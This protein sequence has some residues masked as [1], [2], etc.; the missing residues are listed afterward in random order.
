MPGLLAPSGIFRN[1]SLWSTAKVH[2]RDVRVTTDLDAGYR[3]ATLG[4]AV[5]VKNDDTAAAPVSVEAILRDATGALVGQA[6]ASIARVASG[7]EATVNV[8]YAAANP[9]KWTPRRRALPAVNRTE[10]RQQTRHERHAW[11]VGFRGR[12]PGT[13]GCSSWR[14]SDSR[15]QRHEHSQTQA[16]W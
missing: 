5:A 1:V 6:S 4:I 14:R 13:P 15:R 9:R 16:R 2:V 12:D 7:S 11:R 8:A 3:D 10:G